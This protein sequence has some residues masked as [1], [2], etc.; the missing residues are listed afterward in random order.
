ML[1]CVCVYLQQHTDT[2]KAAVEG[3]Y[4]GKLSLQDFVRLVRLVL[5]DVRHDSDV[6]ESSPAAPLCA[7]AT[8]PPL[9]LLNHCHWCC[10]KESNVLWPLSRPSTVFDVSCDQ[11]KRKRGAVHTKVNS[12]ESRNLWVLSCKLKL[13]KT[14][15]NP[16][17]K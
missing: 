5:G 4:I 9:L 8:S 16:F 10:K 2:H 17:L 11:Q 1:V 3:T 15:T 13:A 6:P 14:R 12:R 7:L